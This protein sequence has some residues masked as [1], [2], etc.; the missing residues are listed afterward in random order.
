M[1]VG[2]GFSRRS[3]QRRE[4]EK[5]PSAEKCALCASVFCRGSLGFAPFGAAQGRRDK[6]RRDPQIPVSEEAGYRCR[7]EGRRYTSTQRARWL[8][9]A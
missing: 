2:V 4:K 9:P 7:P 6:F 8:G 3:K 1:C 5:A